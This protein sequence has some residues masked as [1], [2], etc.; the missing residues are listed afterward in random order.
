VGAFGAV[1][2]CSHS[3][4][5][6]PLSNARPEGPE[7]YYYGTPDHG[8]KELRLPAADEER[9]PIHVPKPPALARRK[10]PP[11]KESEAKV[12]V[13]K[14]TVDSDG[15]AE[16]VPSSIAGRYLGTDTVVIS[17]PGI[18]EEPQVDDKAIVDVVKLTDDTY[19]LTVVAS[20]NG[21]PLCAIKGRLN[22]KT[23]EFEPGQPC[24]GS[25]LGFEI[26]TTLGGGSAEFGSGS[27]DVVFDVALLLSTGAGSLEG[28]VDYSFEGKK[29]AEDSDS[30]E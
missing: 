12:A 26:D 14:P 5:K 7:T 2:S 9:Q 10:P 25:I 29:K 17:F 16:A 1:A 15:G 13:A 8:G 30:A 6:T 11:K 27:V 23:L 18:P 21:D 4:S 19:E 24:F 20:N 22:D 28:S 3:V